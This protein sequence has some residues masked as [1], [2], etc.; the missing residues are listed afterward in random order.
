MRTHISSPFRPG[1]AER[2]RLGDGKS[3][4]V[5]YRIYRHTRPITPQTIGQ[6]QLADEI[7]QYSAFDERSE[8]GDERAG[9]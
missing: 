9:G 6:A 4:T 1:K 8:P 3:P 5:T 7:S 2:D